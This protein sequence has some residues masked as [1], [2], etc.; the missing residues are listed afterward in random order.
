[1]CLHHINL[2]FVANGEGH[3]H[4]QFE[5]SCVLYALLLVR[6]LLLDCKFN[7]LMLQPNDM[8]GI[9]QIPTHEVSQVSRHAPFYGPGRLLAIILSRGEGDS[10]LF[11][12]SLERK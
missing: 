7:K 12:K 6:W 3:E 9:E 5:E 10:I 4:V 2:A 1:M 8:K 11:S